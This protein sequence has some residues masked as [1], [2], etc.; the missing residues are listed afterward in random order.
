MKP[1]TL[2]C[3]ALSC[4]GISICPLL[5]AMPLIPLIMRRLL[6]NCLKICLCRE[7]VFILKPRLTF[8][9]NERIWA[10]CRVFLSGCAVKIDSLFLRYLELTVMG[11]Q[12]PIIDILFSN[13]IQKIL[14]FNHTRLSYSVVIHQWANPDKMYA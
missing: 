13:A 7:E 6:S 11:Q 14:Y 4:S 12:I 2:P 3:G 9:S 1:L 10:T 8:N 5:Y